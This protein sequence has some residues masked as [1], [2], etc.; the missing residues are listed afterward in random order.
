MI[1]RERGTRSYALVSIQ[2]LDEVTGTKLPESWAG[3]GLKV[4]ELAETPDKQIIEAGVGAVGLTLASKLLQEVTR[5]DSGKD[6]GVVRVG[7]VFDLEFK[8][9]VLVVSEWGSEMNAFKF[10]LWE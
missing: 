9:R 1:Q 3:Q 7:E 6:L 5:G 4:N 10:K 8:V 2:H